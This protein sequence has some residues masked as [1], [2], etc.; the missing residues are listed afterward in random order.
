[1]AVIGSKCS[2]GENAHVFEDGKQC[3]GNCY[4]KKKGRR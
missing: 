4:L 1:M 3:C 2:C